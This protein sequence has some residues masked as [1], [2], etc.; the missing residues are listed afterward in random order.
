MKLTKRF[1]M[2]KNKE[3]CR[4]AFEKWWREKVGKLILD[5]SYHTGFE[6]W[7]ACWN[8]KSTE[9]PKDTDVVDDETKFQDA[10]KILGQPDDEF[11]NWHLD[12][13][14]LRAFAA[15][16]RTQQGGN[17]IEV[18]GCGINERGQP[19]LGETS[20]WGGEKLYKKAKPP[21]GDK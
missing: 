14:N 10:L 12:E 15:R 7:Q 9:A 19:Y 13:G 16:F 18:K 5:N 8:L 17:Y 11:N 2:N 4:E 21:V 3:L 1:P 20:T 6:V